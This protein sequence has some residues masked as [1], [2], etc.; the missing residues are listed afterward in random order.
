[1]EGASKEPRTGSWAY[2][3]HALLETSRPVLV[4]RTVRF[5]NCVGLGIAKRE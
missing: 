3:V 1:M 5:G 4:G 2:R